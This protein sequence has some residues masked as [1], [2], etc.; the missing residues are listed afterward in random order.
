M[1]HKCNLCKKE[2]LPVDDINLKGFLIRGWRCKCGNKH[3]DPEDVDNIVR[4]FRIVKNNNT[5][6]NYRMLGPIQRVKND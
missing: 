6:S 4:Y 2:M 1:T 3:S 5:I